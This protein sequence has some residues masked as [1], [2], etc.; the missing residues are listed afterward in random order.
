MFC[1]CCRA[2]VSV[3]SLSL[4]Y[5]HTWRTVCAHVRGDS[6]LILPPLSQRGCDD[7]SVTSL[8]PVLHPPPPPPARGSLACPATL[9]V[10]RSSLDPH[11]I[12]VWSA[13]E[14]CS[15]QLEAA[16]SWA[17]LPFFHPSSLALPRP[18]LFLSSGLTLQHHHNQS[19]S[20]AHNHAKLMGTLSL[21]RGWK[22]RFEAHHATDGVRAHPSHPIYTYQGRQMPTCTL[23]QGVRSLPSQMLCFVSGPTSWFG[24]NDWRK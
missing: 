4:R 10:A 21:A 20:H 15:A 11:C 1:C 18:S 16:A 23:W 19:L 5:Q 8:S 17:S 3:C 7:W 6:W 14:T 22:R 9:L 12:R 2:S 24:P 13:M